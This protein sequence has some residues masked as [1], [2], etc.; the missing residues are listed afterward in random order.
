MPATSSGVVRWDK[1][2][3][4]AQRLARSARSQVELVTG[5][6]VIWAARLASLE[7]LARWDTDRSGEREGVR[8]KVARGKM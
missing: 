2:P 3:S 5:K 7:P 6:V 8:C 1:L 4:A